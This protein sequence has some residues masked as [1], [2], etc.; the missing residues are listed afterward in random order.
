V[1]VRR[2]RRRLCDRRRAVRSRGQ[3]RW[4]TRR[5]LTRN[6]DAT[7]GVRS[8][9]Q[10]TFV[11]LLHQMFDIRPTSR[12]ST[13]SHHALV[14]T[15]TTQN[16]AHWRRV[17]VAGLIVVAAG[18]RHAR[19]ARPRPR[20]LTPVRGAADMGVRLLSASLP[21]CYRRRPQS[22]RCCWRAMK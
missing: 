3:A 21:T 13:D 22:F 9:G 1:V 14:R 2:H 18:G 6:G 10:P 19:G 11:H 4:P 15:A 17:D 16:P 12:T 7:P 20:R 5:V 8:R